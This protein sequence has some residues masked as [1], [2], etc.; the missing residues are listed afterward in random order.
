MLWNEMMGDAL[1]TGYWHLIYE[2]DTSAPSLQ[3]RKII[4]LNI[5]GS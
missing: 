5:F 1:S 2:I 4:L 3:W